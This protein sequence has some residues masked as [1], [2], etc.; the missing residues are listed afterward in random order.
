MIIS[1]LLVLLPFICVLECPNDLDEETQQCQ[2]VN[3]LVLLVVTEEHNNDE[4]IAAFRQAL[5]DN[6]Q[7]GALI[8][9]LALINPSSPITI[10]TGSGSGGGGSRGIQSDPALSVGGIIGII[11]AALVICIG[12]VI[13]QRRTTQQRQEDM[14]QRY[15]SHIQPVE[16]RDLPQESESDSSEQGYAMPFLQFQ[17]SGETQTVLPAGAAGTAGAVASSKKSPPSKREAGDDNASAADVSYENS[18]GWS[19]NLSASMGSI[20]T[21]DLDSPSYKVA[22]SPPSAISGDQSVSKR[23]DDL[24]L[25]LSNGDW[26]MVGASAALLAASQ[27]D[28]TDDPPRSNAT[29]LLRGNMEAPHMDEATAA[30]LEEMIKIGDWEG[31]IQTAA[32]MEATK[33]QNVS[34]D[35]DEEDAGGSSNS[36]TSSGASM[37][38]YSEGGS[39]KSGGSDFYVGQAQISDKDPDEEIKKEVIDLVAKVV[40]EELDNIDE[41]IGQFKGREHELLE[42]LRTMQE[43][44]IALKAKRA[45][46]QQTKLELGGE[47]KDEKLRRKMETIE[48]AANRSQGSIIHDDNDDDSAS[49]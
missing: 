2:R 30:E 20:E 22:G 32:K 5:S 34:M 41:M 27:Q 29:S 36:Q 40:P 14:Q 39:E 23:L 35:S 17:Q 12:S 47:D 6:I 8:E 25:A 28:T 7:D 11:L 33:P 16:S 1:C 37:Q 43:R 4:T 31:V 15:A 24:E 44:D 18:S 21:G 19:D 26:S 9:A 10:N 49:L 45:A 42:T 48:A 3:A 13:L 38:G 46:Q